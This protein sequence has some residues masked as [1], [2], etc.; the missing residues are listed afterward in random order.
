MT[1]HPVRV[2]DEALRQA[3]GSEARLGA[4]GKNPAVGPGKRTKVAMSASLQLFWVDSL[5]MIRA[6]VGTLISA[7]G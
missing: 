6:D 7:L 1:T 2:R 5:L 4:N 3:K